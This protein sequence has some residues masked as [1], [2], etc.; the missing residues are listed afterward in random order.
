MAD[1][2]WYILDKKYYGADKLSL[3]FLQGGT[4]GYDNELRSMHALFIADGPAFKDGYSRA[5]LE[6]IHIYP[7]IAE[8]LGIKPYEKIDGKLEEVRDLLKD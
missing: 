5:S 3:K 2:G 8:I 4:H 6:N 7:L 1:E